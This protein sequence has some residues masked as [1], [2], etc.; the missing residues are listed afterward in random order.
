MALSILDSFQKSHISTDISAA[1]SVEFFWKFGIFYAENSEIGQLVSELDNEELSEDHLAKYKPILSKDE[2][3]SSILESQSYLE[4]SP[5]LIQRLASE[6]GRFFASTTDDEPD[7]RLLLYVCSHGA[8]LE[9]CQFSHK[10]KWKGVPTSDGMMQIPYSQI[11]KRR[12]IVETLVEVQFN[13]EQG[14]VVLVHPRL[15]IQ[16]K[17]GFTHIYG[18]QGNP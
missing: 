5:F 6:P 8:M 17:N 18:L 7:N 13:L 16:M 9:L 4:S 1:A 12:K 11:K 3:I 15:A 10:Q 14:G 2:R